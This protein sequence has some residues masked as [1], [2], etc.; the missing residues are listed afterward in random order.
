M[1][2]DRIELG[3]RVTVCLPPADVL[4][5]L[6]SA[7]E[8]DA[9]EGDVVGVCGA[10]EEEEENRCA[11]LLQGIIKGL[12]ASGASVDAITYCWVLKCDDDS[13]FFLL[14]SKHLGLS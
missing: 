2:E 10:W 8:I 12:K 14:L 11:A 3:D 9:F 7:V 6:R 1:S 4:A 13:V 5:T